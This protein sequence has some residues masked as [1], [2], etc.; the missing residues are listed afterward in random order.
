[1]SDTYRSTYITKRIDRIEFE[2]KQK[3][4]LYLSVLF[5]MHWIIKYKL[6]CNKIKRLILYYFF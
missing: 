3:L 1:M 4:N 2:Y 5:I 6:F